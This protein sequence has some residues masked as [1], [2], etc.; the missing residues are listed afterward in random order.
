MAAAAAVPPVASCRCA[1]LRAGHADNADRP[2]CWQTALPAEAM[3]AEI[4]R[5]VQRAEEATR[6]ALHDQD[7]PGK[8]PEQMAAA[9]RELREMHGPDGTPRFPDVGRALHDFIVLC[10]TAS[11]LARGKDAS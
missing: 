5:Q 11:F 6:K 2:L 9:F 1:V 3:D 8:T 10:Q 7:R 4:R